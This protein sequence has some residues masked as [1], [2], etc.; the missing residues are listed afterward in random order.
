MA[1]F[2]VDIYI[3]FVHIPY[4]NNNS[5]KRH[6]ATLKYDTGTLPIFKISTKECI[7]VRFSM[8]PKNP[9]NMIF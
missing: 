7:F 1:N 4:T 8:R 3:G 5:E 2:I 6:S 9:E